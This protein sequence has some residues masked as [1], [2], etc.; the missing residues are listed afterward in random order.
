MTKTDI[1]QNALSLSEEDRAELANLLWESLVPTDP[2]RQLEYEQA[3]EGEIQRRLDEIRSGNATLL[4]S[5][6]AWEIID[7]DE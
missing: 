1:Y 2:A 6:E 4:T 3:W 7:S 5:E